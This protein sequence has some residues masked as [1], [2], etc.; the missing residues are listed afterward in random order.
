MPRLSISLVTSAISSFSLWE[1]TDREESDETESRKKT[2][3]IHSI[4]VTCVWCL[5]LSRT[6]LEM[7]WSHRQ[8]NPLHMV[9]C[10]SYI[11]LTNTSRQALLREEMTQKKTLKVQTW[12][13]LSGQLILPHDRSF[14]EQP[15]S[16]QNPLWE[17][18]HLF[19]G[20]SRPPFLFPCPCSS[21]PL[22]WPRFIS[23]PSPMTPPLGCLGAT[24]VWRQE[25]AGSKTLA[26]LAEL[27][28]ANP[29]SS[30]VMGGKKRGEKQ[31]EEH[32]AQ[33]KR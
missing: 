32:W 23:V 22:C 15:P 6:P 16:A 10:S 9:V 19:C 11:S 26:G 8:P 7:L 30:E 5:T 17:L 13:T 14:V 27:P 25:Y 20:Q 21:S 1:Q 2:T 33:Q 12:F 24:L 28:G 3:D 31:M 18:Q 29:E 4:H